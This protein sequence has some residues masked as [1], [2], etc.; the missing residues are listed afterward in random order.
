MICTLLAATATV[1]IVVAPR[2]TVIVAA[3]PLVFDT[4][5]AK[6]KTAESTR[7]AVTVG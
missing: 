5:T 6:V 2:V 7:F 1:A 3:D 4:A